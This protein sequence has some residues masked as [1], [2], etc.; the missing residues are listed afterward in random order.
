[1]KP[2]TQNKFNYEIFFVILFY[3]SLNT[4]LYYVLAKSVYVTVFF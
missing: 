4:V 2:G 3:K 1:M